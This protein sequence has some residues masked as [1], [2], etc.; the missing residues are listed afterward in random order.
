MKRMDGF[1]LVLFLAGC[2]NPCTKTGVTTARETSDANTE[3]ADADFDASSKQDDDDDDDDVLPDAGSLCKPSV[4]VSFGEGIP[5][6]SITGFPCVS[7]NQETLAYAL[8]DGEQSIFLVNLKSGS[9]LKRFP[10]ITKVEIERAL[11]T[12]ELPPK[13]RFAARAAE[14]S[15]A[16]K[17]V[18]GDW[19]YASFSHG[20]DELEEVPVQAGPYILMLTREGVLN[21]KT[22]A[23]ELLYGQRLSE[24]HR[25]QRASSALALQDIA[26][27]PEANTI[28]L[29]S[30]VDNG[31]STLRIMRWTADAGAPPKP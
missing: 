31:P 11:E 3:D 25:G 8:S 18:A 17:E 22:Q 20:R 6:F 15:H 29:R 1:V 13:A 9:V 7:A 30:N 14:I 23:G 4:N 21:V 16:L 26:T 5:Q 27:V 19:H 10:L 2:G 28:V 24:W 12:E